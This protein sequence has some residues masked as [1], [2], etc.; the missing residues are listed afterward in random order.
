MN[1]T[2]RRALA[3]Y[4]ADQLLAGKSPA[5]LAKQLAAIM[6]ESGRSGERKFLLDDIA[7]ELEHRRALVIGHVS[8]VSPLTKGLAT[9]LR[10]QLKRA[11]K[12]REVLLDEQV[13]KSVLGGL[14]V[15]TSVNVWDLSVSRE[16]AKL[17]ETF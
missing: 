4:G 5:A 1:K 13:D 3:R 15:E 7:W 14:R 8:T 16:L 12:A 10:A 9:A 17:R 11:T 6:V 2:S